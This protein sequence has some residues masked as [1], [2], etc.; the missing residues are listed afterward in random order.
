MSFIA[1][2]IF[3]LIAGFVASKVAGRSGGLLTDIILGVVGA[4]IGGWLFE[5]F[6]MRGVTGFNFGSLL[7]AII[8][9]VLLLVAFRLI[10]KT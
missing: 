8:G 2:I 3:G 7:V 1:W 4:V 10:K 9:A 6:G 5:S